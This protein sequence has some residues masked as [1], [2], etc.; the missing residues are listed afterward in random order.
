[1]AGSQST[2]ADAEDG[3]RD[4]SVANVEVERLRIDGGAGVEARYDQV[5]RHETGGERTQERASKRFCGKRHEEMAHTA[6]AQD[7]DQTRERIE[8][9]APLEHE[10]VGLERAEAGGIEPAR[11]TIVPQ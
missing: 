9:L 1:M 3:E 11:L 7:A 5:H 6:G 4:G 8:R 10:I 2:R